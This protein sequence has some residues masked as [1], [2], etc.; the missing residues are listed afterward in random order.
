MASSYPG[1]LDTLP[2]SHQNNVNEAVNATDV[3]NLADAIN[4]V[5]AALGINPS[6]S[7]ASVVNRL[8]QIETPPINFQNTAAYTLVAGDASTVVGII[9]SV[10]STITIPPHSSVPFPVGT[11]IMI[12]QGVSVPTLTIAPGAGVT[13]ESRGSSYSLAGA[14]AWA[15]LIQISQDTWDLI[16]DLA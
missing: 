3:N 7:Y 12:R 10:A 8:N 11:T 2:T 9:G 14:L 1:A 16:G 15:T 6:G 4:K 5:E 13:L